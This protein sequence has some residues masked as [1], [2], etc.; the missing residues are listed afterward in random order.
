MGGSLHLEQADTGLLTRNKG[1]SEPPH[2][3]I[4]RELPV[5][6]YLLSGAV[7]AQFQAAALTKDNYTVE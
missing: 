4:V 1:V 6:R 2:L 3:A 5:D 7:F